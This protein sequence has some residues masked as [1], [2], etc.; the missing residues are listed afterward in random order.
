MKCLITVVS[1]WNI[2]L[3]LLF[4]NLAFISVTCYIKIETQIEA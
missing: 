1:L 3:Y 2:Y 4:D